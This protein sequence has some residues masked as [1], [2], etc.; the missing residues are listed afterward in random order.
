MTLMSRETEVV[1]VSQALKE[2][3]IIAALKLS[4]TSQVSLG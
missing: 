1:T 2:T 3:L 4:N